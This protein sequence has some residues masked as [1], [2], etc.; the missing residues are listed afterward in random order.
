MAG[1][2]SKAAARQRRYRQRLA[3]GM[4]V[5]KVEIPARAVEDMIGLQ[6]LSDDEADSPGHVQVELAAMLAE[7]I[8]I[9]KKT[10]THNK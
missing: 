4:M 2:S 7:Y 8:S 9:L 3:R 5:Y 10:V 1:P 6:R